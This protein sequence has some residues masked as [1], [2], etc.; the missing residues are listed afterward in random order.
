MNLLF[1]TLLGLIPASSGLLL[2]GS[3][4]FALEMLGERGFILLSWAGICLGLVSSF[5]VLR[6]DRI[7]ASLALGLGCG[8]LSLFSAL[9][10][11]LLL[12]NDRQI[13]WSVAPFA[14]NSWLL[15]ASALYSL[16]GFTLA[17]RQGSRLGA[18]L[19]PS[20]ALW[21]SLLLLGWLW[22]WSEAI[23]ELEGELVRGLWLL[24]HGP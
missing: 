3:A 15:L 1:P 13:Y 19:F 23:Q 22:T 24:L 8:L 7:L 9:A 12:I 10:L 6:E 5:M 20:S 4:A 17:A 18:F 16:M 2:L 21:F 14:W 11:A